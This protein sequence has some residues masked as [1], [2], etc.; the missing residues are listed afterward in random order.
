MKQLLISLPF[1]LVFLISLSTTTLGQSPAQAPSSTTPQ[2]KAHAPV[3][4]APTQPAAQAP[5]EVPLV[6]APPRKAPNGPTNVTKILEKAGGFSV[7]IRILKNTQVINQ[8]EIQLNNSNN[9]LTIFAPTNDAFS[10]LKAGTL[11]SLATEEKVQLLQYHLL[12]SFI[13]IS[14]F[15]TVSNP[16][17]TQ[18]SDTYEYPLNITTTGSI[19]NISTGLVNTTISGTVYSDNQLA[20]YKVDRVL[21]P[22]GIFA[23]KA[24]PPAKATAPSLAPAALKSKPKKEEDS[25]YD[26]PPV[27]ALDNLSGGLALTANAMASIGV[28]FMATAVFV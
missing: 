6:Q 27:K 16:V 26:I 22:L 18:A 7:F 4:Q 14:S 5:T 13:P 20:I 17:R 1:F 8:I 23:P 12:P 15:Q 9:A 28:A 19:V 10:G 2:A 11:N 21:L 3:A 25:T 24:K